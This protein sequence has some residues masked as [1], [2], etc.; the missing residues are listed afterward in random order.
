MSQP[1]SVTF[2]SPYPISLPSPPSC[3]TQ[4]RSLCSAERCPSFEASLGPWRPK[5]SLELGPCCT[6]CVACCRCS[7]CCCCGSGCLQRLQK[8]FAACRCHIL[9]LNAAASATALPLL[10]LPLSAFLIYLLIFTIFQLQLSSHHASTP[11]PPTSPSLN[12]ICGAMFSLRFISIPYS[13]HSTFTS[14]QLAQRVC[15]AQF[16]LMY[17]IFGNIK[18]FPLQLRYLLISNTSPWGHENN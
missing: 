11:P 13:R 12:K 4:W 15:P 6:A 10:L 17:S 16:P 2:S 3:S 1:Q 18:R 14:T 9:L 5:L 8:C 7:C